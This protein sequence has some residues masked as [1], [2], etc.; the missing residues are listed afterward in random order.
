MN[1]LFEFRDLSLSVLVLIIETH[2][3]NPRCWWRAEIIRSL[4]RFEKLNQTA[5]TRR[6]DD[7]ALSNAV[8]STPIYKNYLRRLVRSG[9]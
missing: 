1:P 4:D 9:S 8:I 5:T 2:Q 3:A 7:A 6:C